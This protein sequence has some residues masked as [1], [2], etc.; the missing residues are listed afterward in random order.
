MLRDIQ[1][2][3]DQ[4]LDIN[5]KLNPGKC[6]F[7][8]EEGKFLGVIVTNDGFKANP[9]KVQAIDRMPP[10]SIKD[11]QTLMGHMVALNRFL[12]NYASRSFPF[13]NTLKNVLKKTQFRWTPEAETVFREMKECLTHLPTLTAPLPKEHLTLY[14]S[15]SD[16]V[17]GAVLL[18]DRKGA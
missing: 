14:L 10:N 8:M 3:F 4:L 13:V 17:I 15:A 6:F 1:R 11:V 9:E 12:S 5:M 2:T 7:G 16:K 18:V